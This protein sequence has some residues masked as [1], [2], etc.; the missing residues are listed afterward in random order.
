[1]AVAKVNTPSKKATREKLPP[2]KLL[3]E[4]RAIIKTMTTH[5]EEETFVAKQRAHQVADEQLK[6]KKAGSTLE[7]LKNQRKEAPRLLI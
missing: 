4:K 3:L 6:R 1:M 5:M 2:K 7:L